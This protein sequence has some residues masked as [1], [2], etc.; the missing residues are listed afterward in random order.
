MPQLAFSADGKSTAFLPWPTNI[1]THLTYVRVIP[2]DS[3]LD[4]ELSAAQ[5]ASLSPDTRQNLV[6]LFGTRV[7]IRELVS[8]RPLDL[9]TSEELEYHE[10]TGGSHPK[11]GWARSRELNDL[12]KTIDPSLR[13]ASLHHLFKR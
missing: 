1:P 9:W 6:R 11:D 8:S 2:D 5:L 3:V 13:F 10:E 12:L 4:T 7:T